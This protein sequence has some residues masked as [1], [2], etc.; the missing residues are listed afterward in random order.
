M[1]MLRVTVATAL[2]ASAAPA[3]A[4]ADLREQLAK[5]VV[6]ALISTKQ[7]SQLQLCAAD[8]IGEGLLPVPFPADAAGTIHIFG[9]AGLMGAGTVQRVVSLAKTSDGTRLEIRT[10]SGR[11]D[12]KLLKLL[13]NCI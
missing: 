13:R 4:D 8:A 10:R 9:F 6:A 7:P 3:Q 5:P 2:A 12:D 1:R 11:P